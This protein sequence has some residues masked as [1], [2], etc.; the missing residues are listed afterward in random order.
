[1]TLWQCSRSSGKPVKDKHGN[2]TL[3]Y[4]HVAQPLIKNI[5]RCPYCRN[6]KIPDVEFEKHILTKH[7][8]MKDGYERGRKWGYSEFKTSAERQ[9]TID[10]AEEFGKALDKRYKTKDKNGKYKHNIMDDL[11]DMNTDPAG[12]CK[13]IQCDKMFIYDETGVNMCKKCVREMF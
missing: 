12:N 13:C 3:Q 8:D 11:K 9:Q 2:S 6:N 7:P 10:D 4:F 5:N 1:M